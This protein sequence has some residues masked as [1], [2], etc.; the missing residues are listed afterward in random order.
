MILLLKSWLGCEPPV[1][2]LCKR[3]ERLYFGDAVLT[4][5]SVTASCE[6]SLVW[7]FLRPTRGDSAFVVLIAYPI[8]WVA[9][10]R[11][12]S[13]SSDGARVF[14]GLGGYNMVITDPAF[15]TAVRNLA[16]WAQSVPAP[17]ADFAGRGLTRRGACLRLVRFGGLP[18]VVGQRAGSLTQQYCENLT[19]G[20]DLAAKEWGAGW[21]KKSSSEPQAHVHAQ[22]EGERERL[23]DA[24]QS[25]L[26][27]PG[28]LAPMRLFPRWPE[29]SMVRTNPVR[30][31]SRPGAE[32]TTEQ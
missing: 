2:I 29:S 11:S 19:P 13:K 4:R 31:V 17:N 16:L 26:T 21:R 25:V 5:Q 14:I 23:S 7:Y 32:Q 9:E 27:R 6:D 28:R 18:E 8:L 15:W 22:P 10:Q 24:R 12:F 30:L 1:D 3:G 20:N